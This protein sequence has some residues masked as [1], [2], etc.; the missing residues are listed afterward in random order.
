MLKK[1][2]LIG[3]FGMATV[4]MSLPAAA[5]PFCC[6]CGYCWEQEV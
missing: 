1:I 4:S 2:A 3:A 6:Y 5:G